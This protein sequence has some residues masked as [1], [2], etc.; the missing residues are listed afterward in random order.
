MLDFSNSFLYL[1]ALQNIPFQIQKHKS[2][3]KPGR[4]VFN[5]QDA[6]TAQKGE[7]QGCYQHERV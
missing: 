6:S 4:I 7:Y 3:Q 5:H 1:S 2:N